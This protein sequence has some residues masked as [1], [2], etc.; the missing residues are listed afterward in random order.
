MA[1]RLLS[2]FPFVFALMLSFS[3][4]EN[5]RYF[6]PATAMLTLLAALGVLSVPTLAVRVLGFFGCKARSG[7]FRARCGS[8][9]RGPSAR[10]S[11]CLQLT[12]WMPGKP[13]LIRYDEAFREDDIADLAAW[14]RHNVPPD[15]VIVADH[16]AGL[17]N[18]ARKRQI[19]PANQVPQQLR[20][21]KLASDEGSLDELRSQG[22]GYV[23]VSE[24]SYGKFFREDLRRRTSTTARIS[25]RRASMRNCSARA[26]CSSSATARR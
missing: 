26:S 17:Q 19:E 23:V 12:G 1:E 7:S 11:A 9:R 5:D 6:L 10:C 22:V 14:L 25:R 21:S 8:A 20:V 2:A 3:P 4:K 15:A 13:G 18:P 24:T 16:R